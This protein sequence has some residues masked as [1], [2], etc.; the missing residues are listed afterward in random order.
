MACVRKMT[1]IASS[2]EP[3]ATVQMF[4]AHSTNAGQLSEAA[5]YVGEVA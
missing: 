3:G 4:P 5:T 1:A 2:Q